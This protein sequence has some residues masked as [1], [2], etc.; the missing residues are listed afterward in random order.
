MNFTPCPHCGERNEI[1][2][3]ELEKHIIA[4]VCKKCGYTVTKL[5]GGIKY[6]D[7][8]WN[9]NNGNLFLKHMKDGDVVTLWDKKPWVVV[10]DKCGV[11]ALK[12][13]HDPFCYSIDQTKFD[14]YGLYQVWAIPESECD[15]YLWVISAPDWEGSGEGFVALPV[16]SNGETG[17]E[18]SIGATPFVEETLRNLVK[19]GYLIPEPLIEFFAHWR[20]NGLPDYC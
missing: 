10:T 6:A 18:I 4:T 17:E 3:Y 12:S 11:R 2:P 20:E 5:E 19:K 1:S 13:Q 7:E 8:Y 9:V 15:I 16:N 14:P